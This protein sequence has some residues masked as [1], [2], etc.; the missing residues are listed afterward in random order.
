MKLDDLFINSLAPKEEQE[1]GHIHDNF[2]SMAK[3][4]EFF[5][6]N[7]ADAIALVD[8][9]SSWSYATLWD[10]AQ[11]LAHFIV[12]ELKPS[13][14]TSIA[15]LT[16]RNNYHY[17]AM[18]GVWLA[19]C[20]A[21]P[22]DPSLPKPRLRHMI[23]DCQAEILV[24]DIANAGLGERISQDCKALH[25]LICL[26]A[27]LFEDAVEQKTNLMNK[28][29][30]NLIAQDGADGSW[31]SYFD[32]KPLTH[33]SLLGMAQNVCTKLESFFN[34]SHNILDIGGGSG[35]VAKAIMEKSHNYTAFELCKAEAQRINDYGQKYSKQYDGLHKK[36][37]QAHVM[38]ASDIHIAPQNY[39]IIIINSVIENFPGYNYLRHVL[40]GAL[41]HLENDGAVFLGMVWD[42][43]KKQLFEKALYDYAAQSGDSSAILRFAAEEELYVSKAFFE[44][45][46]L[47][48][49]DITIEFSSPKSGLAELDHYRYDVII[50]KN[51]SKQEYTSTYSKQ[52]F[53]LKHV[54]HAKQKAAI[55]SLDSTK[56]TDA[57]YIIYTS[58]STGKPKGALLEHISLMNL[59]DN[60]LE[61]VYAPFNQGQVKSA[62][63]ASFCFDASL[64]AWATLCHGGTLFITA[65]NLRHNPQQ[66]HNFFYEN[67]IILCDAT[68]SLFG[69]MLDFWQ[70]SASTPHV[71]VWILGG[72]VLHLHYLSQ[73]Y[74]LQNQED[75]CIFNAYGPTEC[76]V[77]TTLHKFS[78]DNWQEHSSPPLGKKLNGF[79]VMIC[80]AKGHAVPDGIPAELWIGGLGL[81]RGYVHNPQLT[82]EAFIHKDGQR[83]YKS[84]DIVCR[85]NGLIFY[86]A[87]EDGQVKINGY[88]IEVS[89]VEAALKAC[90]LVEQASIVV[91][92]FL[93]NNMPALAAYVVPSQ[94]IKANTASPDYTN[95]VETSLRAYLLQ[96]LPSYAVPAFFI[97]IHTLPLTASGKV[98]RKSLPSPT[99]TKKQN[100]AR[101]AS[102]G[103]SVQGQVEQALADMWSKLLGQSI[104]DAEAD[105]FTLGGHSI[106]GVRLLGLIE[107][108]FKRRL[109]LSAIFTNPSIAQQ[110][111]LISQMQDQN[112]SLRQGQVQI[113][114]LASSEAIK[115]NLFLF[116][117]AGGSTV[118]YAKLAKILSHSMNIYAVE[119]PPLLERHDFLASTSKMAQ[120][121]AKAILEHLKQTNQQQY[122]VGGWSFGGILALETARLLQ[123]SGLKEKALIIIDTTLNTTLQRNLVFMDEVDF[124]MALL[125]EDMVGIGEDFKQMNKE[126][127]LAQLVHRGIEQGRLPSG[128]NEEHMQALI[129]TFHANALAGARYTP[130]PLACNALLLRAQSIDK[131]M[132]PSEDIYLGWREHILHDLQLQWIAGT[133]E[134]ILQDQNVEHMAKAIHDYRGSLA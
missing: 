73:F 121:Y 1:Q 131:N 20:V 125:G 107:A 13:S 89:E 97:P 23:N 44:D 129:Q 57:A 70:Q 52:R 39:D 93:G 43:D 75:A 115:E 22:L 42:A 98:D 119:P 11:E 86:I 37:V 82:K 108:H 105:F 46:A 127:R 128:F 110:A 109:P 16:G 79:N 5:A 78:A 117:P 29:L 56:N 54:Q 71:K 132:G 62:V 106:L 72:E 49:G 67:N 28:E 50:T 24:T 83:W 48:R 30:W 40:H 120:A 25:R 26:E 68:P 55:S 61:Q 88:R 8:S 87:R 116:H 4:I 99:A 100:S 103:R 35:I 64:Q 123:A 3:R 113:L 94:S 112:H 66:L 122:Y 81:A 92:D 134:T 36:T 85:R 45:F 133:H 14:E 65:D 102:T 84:G 124:L 69:L 111:K 51:K 38:E 19:R 63:L 34:T 47:Q 9:T 90:P 118:C 58:G 101:I 32:A 33:E 21:V 104:H 91:G 27:M 80:A 59:M 7:H 77:N 12:G 60:M 18:L 126:E 15:I 96:K 130:R 6:Q 41:E 2:V 95:T 53:G 10:K 74:A 76:C 17:A 31:K 114:E